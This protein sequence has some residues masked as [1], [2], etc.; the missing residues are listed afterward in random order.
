[1]Q[2]NNIF[3]NLN[4]VPAG[5]VWLVGAG[6]GEIGLLTLAAVKAIHSADCLVYDAL[7]N[8]EILDLASDTTQKIYSGKRGGKPSPQ[9]QDISLRLVE[10]ARQGKRVVRLKGGDPFVFGR[11]GEEALALIKHQ[12]PFKVI[13]GVTS[14]VAG[15]T[16]AGIPITHRDYNSVVSFITGHNANN[17]EVDKVDWTTLASTGGTL[18]LYMTLHRLDLIAAKLIKGG[19]SKNEPVALISNATLREQ[20]V[21]ETTLDECRKYCSDWNIPTPCIVVVGKNVA[22]RSQLNWL[23]QQD[24]D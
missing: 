6:P 9:Q 2:F 24:V 5:H 14:G 8:P 10:L 4:S 3:N 17:E 21:K 16:Y 12:I 11:G 13:P 23:E 7:I 1:M 22:L 20:S 18:V 15:P 19:R